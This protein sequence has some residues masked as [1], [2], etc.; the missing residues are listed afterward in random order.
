MT[1]NTEQAEVARFLDTEV[2]EVGKNKH[3]VKCQRC[4]SVILNDGVGTL[5]EI[6]FKLPNMKKKGDTEGDTEEISHFWMVPDMFQF[7]NVGFS[8][9]VGNVKFLVCA[10]CEVGP[11]GWHDLDTKLSYVA[12][13]RVIYSE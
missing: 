13:N 5:K 10:D 3:G 4:P 12:L 11:I 7:E 6:S 2:S 8:N 1:E 9:T